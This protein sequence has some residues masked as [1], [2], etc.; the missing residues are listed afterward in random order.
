MLDSRTLF[1]HVALCEHRVLIAF[2][3]AFFCEFDLFYDGH[4]RGAL[5]KLTVSISLGLWS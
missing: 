1:E 5:I 4:S 3:A 2:F